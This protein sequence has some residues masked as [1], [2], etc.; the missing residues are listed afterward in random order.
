MAMSFYQ[1]QR[2]QNPDLM[3]AKLEQASI[4]NQLRAQEKQGYLQS[5]AALAPLAP[6]GAWGQLGASMT[7]G[8]ANAANVVTPAVVGEGGALAS[9]TP[10]A[11]ALMG[12][13]EAATGTA[14][15]EAAGAGA[16][17]SSGLM[18]GLAALGPMGWAALAA[19]GLGLAK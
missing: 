11:A 4:A 5:G 17:A 18:S 19:I 10:E 7:P 8:A 15:A 9:A 14:L 12:G 1:A 3:R 2:P 6:E 13:A 16:G